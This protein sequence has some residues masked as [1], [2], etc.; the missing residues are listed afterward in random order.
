MYMYIY[1]LDAGSDYETSSREISS[2]SVNLPTKFRV[3][4]SDL[5]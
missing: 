3:V 1:R 5:K 4:D 2:H